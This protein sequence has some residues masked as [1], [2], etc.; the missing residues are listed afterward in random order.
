MPDLHDT[1]LYAHV[2]AGSL[3]VVLG[4]FALWIERSAPYRS[5]AGSAYCA[6]VLLTSLT[7]LAL[8]AS[9]PE[10]LWWLSILAVLAAALA[11]MGWLAPRRRN[12][13]W[14]R[15]YAHGQGGSYISLVT[16]LLVVSVS[17]PASVA[18]WSVPTLIGVPMIERRV[19]GI[20]QQFR[21]RGAA[22]GRGRLQWEGD[23]S[24]DL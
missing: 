4:P 10:A 16:A 21:D 24:A 14:V 11:S 23:G 15:M 3:G 18:A 8:I 12:R 9:D 20:G 17:G 5:R 1:A 7:A 13:G 6:A 2:A 19:N 22:G